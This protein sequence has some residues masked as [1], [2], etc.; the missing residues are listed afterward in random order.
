MPGDYMTATGFNGTMEID[1]AMVII[2][3]GKVYKVVG[4]SLAGEKQIPISSILSVRFKAATSM[5]NGFLQIGV[6]GGSVVGGRSAI[7]A[8]TDENAV[9][10]RPKQ[11]PA[12]ERMYAYLQKRAAENAKSAATGPIVHA[13]APDLADQIRKLAE[14]RDQGVVS[15]TEFQTKKAELL[16]RM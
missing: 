11:Q 6:L 13:P 3:H 7:A 14:L 16:E 1:D 8:A 10:F 15:E 9:M 12:F 2:R 4:G 5:W